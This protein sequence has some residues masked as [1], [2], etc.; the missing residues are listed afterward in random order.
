M[1][2]QHSIALDSA[3]AAGPTG[4]LMLVRSPHFLRQPRPTGAHKYPV[5]GPVTIASQ[6]LF[7]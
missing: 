6:G 1:A 4:R 3:E 7:I 2:Q 5:P